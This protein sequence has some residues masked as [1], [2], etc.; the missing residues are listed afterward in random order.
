LYEKDS[1]G[2][3]GVSQRILNTLSYHSIPLTK[4]ITVVLM[5]EKNPDTLEEMLATILPSV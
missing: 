4:K 1:L 2:K 3:K 5:G